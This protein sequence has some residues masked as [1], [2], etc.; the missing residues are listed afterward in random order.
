MMKLKVWLY[1]RLREGAKR[2]EQSDAT[3]AKAAGYSLSIHDIDVAEQGLQAL[4]AKAPPDLI[5]P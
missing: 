2:L 5:Q 3:L 1:Q 4:G